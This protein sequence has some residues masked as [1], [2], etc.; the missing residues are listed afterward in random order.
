MLSLST[1]PLLSLLI[2][3]SDLLNFTLVTHSAVAGDYETRTGCRAVP[4]GL[5][6]WPW[7]SATLLRQAH[8]ALRTCAGLSQPSHCSS[9]SGLGDPRA[10]LI[11]SSLTWEPRLS[12]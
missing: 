12:P 3:P 11:S 9:R 2:C 10:H 1:L 7:R 8:T 6:G 5:L 4:L